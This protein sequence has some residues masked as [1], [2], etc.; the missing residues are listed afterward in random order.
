MK[1]I[2]FLALSLISLNVFANEVQMFHCSVYNDTEREIKITYNFNDGSYKSYEKRQSE[3]NW[4]LQFVSTRTAIIQNSYDR[5]PSFRLYNGAST[6][7][8]SDISLAIKLNKKFEAGTGQINWG[9]R[10]GRSF[11]NLLD[12][13]KGSA[14]LKFE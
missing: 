3:Q 10:D 13:C 12:N 6:K 11:Y 1:L 7:D 14:I 9:T 5:E 2:Q 8:R 4:K